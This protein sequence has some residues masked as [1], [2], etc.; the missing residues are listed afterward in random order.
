MVNVREAIESRYEGLATITVLES[1]RVNGVT[2]TITTE[3]CKNQPCRLS[4]KSGNTASTNGDL[5]TA[6]QE[7]KLFISPDVEIPSSSKIVVT[8]HN[9]TNE[10]RRSGKPMVY[11]N[12]QEI[13]LELIETS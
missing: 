3:L 4:Y 13:L 1:R 11:T 5:P 12:H 6:Y 9:V 8:Q 2:K 7:I 10:Y